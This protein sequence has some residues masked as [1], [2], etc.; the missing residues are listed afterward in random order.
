MPL[1]PLSWIHAFQLTL[2]QIRDIILEVNA[3]LCCYCLQTR[4]INYIYLPC[5][6]MACCAHEFA[7]V[8]ALRALNAAIDKGD[9]AET[10]E[11]LKA[12]QLNIQDLDE[13][14]TFQ[15]QQMLAQTKATLGRD[16]RVALHEHGCH[17]SS[18]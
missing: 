12:R 4:F 1:L 7:V 9:A 16:V 11:C 2:Q 6:C 13:S 15:Y 14:G 3:C 17:A 8:R 18:S 5:T 10:F